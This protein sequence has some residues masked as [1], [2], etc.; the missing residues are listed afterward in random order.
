MALEQALQAARQ[1]ELAVLESLHAA[2]QLGPWLRDPL[3]ALP[4][5]HAARA[6]KLH[7]LR[8][9]VEEAALPAAARARNGATPAHDAAATGHLACLQWLLS[10]GDCRVQDKDSS[11][12][13]ALHLAARFG[14][15]EVVDW[16]LRHGSGDPTAA[17]DMG[18]L[19][20][21]YA[22]A[23]GDFPSLRL[24]I[25]HHPEG[26][27]AQIK[28]GAT[29]LYLACQEGHLEVT[30]YLVQE[31]GAD[32]HLSAH[33][34]MTPLHAA[35]QMGHSSIIVWLV[36]CTDVSLSEQDQDG[37]TAM[38][39]AASRGHAKVLSWLLLHGGEISADLW[40]G[41][42]LHDAAENGELECC[43]ILVV[44]GAELDVRDRDGYTA[45]DLSDYNGHSHCTR[46]LRTVENLSVEH[47]VLSRDPSAELETKQ[48]DSGMSSPNTTMSVQPLNFDLSSPTST[49]SNYDSCSSSQS[50]VK[51][52]CPPRGGSALKAHPGAQSPPVPPLHTGACGLSPAGPPSTRAADI[53]SYMDMLSPE[54]NLAQGE[55]EKTTAPPPPPSFPPPPPP[56]GTQLPPP[57]PGYPAPKPPVGLQAAD[58]YMQTKSKLRHVE[59]QAIRK[60]P[61]SRD[62]HDGLRR[63]DSGRKPRAFS[64]QPSTGDYYRQL[65]RCPRE[66]PAAR[67]GMAHSEEAALLPGNHVHNGCA[68]DPKASRELPPPPPPPPPPLPEGLSSPPP[69]PP[70]PLEGAGPGCGQRRS[71]SSTGSTKSFNMMA[72]TGDNSELLAEIKAGK[73]LKPTPQSKG[74]TTVFSG[75]GQPASQPDSPLP[76]ASPAASRARSPT[77][78]AMGP[79]P[80]LNGSLAPAPPSTP[81]PGVQLDVEALIPT[82]DEQG[83]PI[84]EWKRQV[85]VRKM[86]LKMQEEEEQRRKLTSASSCC[87]PREGWRYSREYNGILGPFGELMTE[88][89]ILRIEQQIENLQV[90]HKAQKLEARL[91]Q[92]ELELEQLL[93]I[94]A[95]LSAP[96]FTVDPRRMH[97][98][99]ASLPA[100]CSKISTLL[101]S[102]ATLLAALGGRPTHLADLL[103]ADTGLPLAP[104]PDAPWRPGP[105]CLGRSH[106]LSWCREAVAREILE[107]GVSVQHLRATYELRSQGSAPPRSPRRKYSLSPGAP[108]REPILEED[109]MAAGTGEPSAAAATNSLPP[110]AYLDPPEVPG[111]QAALPEPE[112]LARRPPL[113]TELRGVQDYIDMRKERIVYLFLEHWRKWTFHGHG[114]QAQTRL[115][116]LLPRVVAAG[117]DPVPEAL[118]AAEVPQPPAGDG[119]DKRLL[120]LLKQRQVVGKLLGHWRSLLRQVPARQPCGPGLAHGLYW[121]EHFL[122]P[123]DGGAPPRYDSLTLDLFMLGYF[124][125]LEMGLSR[126]ERKFRHLLCYEM[127]DRLGSHPWELI[128]EFHRVVL[129]EVEAG[130]RGWSDGFEDLKHQFFGDSP[131]AKLAW[132]EEVKKEQ[133]EAKK[134]QEKEKEEK[135]EEREPAR[136]AVP[137]QTED[138][139][140]GHPEAPGP[141]P[142]PPPPPPPAAPPPTPSDPPSS[143][144]PAEDSL[145]L[146]SGMGEF[147][148]EDICRYIDRSFSFWKEKEAELFDI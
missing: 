142:Q 34:G 104:L 107:C 37:A 82:H 130:R 48:P 141:A 97:G 76:P 61:S 31:C 17:T 124:Q 148:D 67:P 121:P 111:R 12:A 39:F 49:L 125:L 19:P 41:T 64:K 70:L 16:L 87:Y 4:V 94:S 81:A 108:G 78:P 113:P 1:G 56:P 26:A 116:R 89:D 115:R 53:Q 68:A 2:G 91:K 25:R 9:L 136:E 128:R 133:E 54:L 118:E 60:E 52:R 55:M 32:P 5:H 23:K 114:R 20:I 92:L 74:L 33:D 144:A 50:S 90:L 96:R 45:A 10:Q 120:R 75:S 135:E 43:Q 146:L 101:K 102:M 103:A 46:Y 44:N 58:I 73:S 134:E 13:T 84:P 38:H 127:F 131:E 14:H 42:P 88:A 95:A 83:R 69:A 77:P 80:L 66:P 139:P 63:Q 93:P 3:D 129:E 18:A 72:P 110:Q 30:Q 143:E 6:G 62:G 123:L 126:E 65:G 27:N 22:A 15:P 109:Y 85:M 99:A 117:A 105:L 21:H 29:P 47:R 137:A 145:E 132:E 79:Q 122:P 112:Q 71:S 59:N 36:T 98:R 51:G 86:Q 138:W 140:E 40:G 57:P 100:W 24:L 8:F 147:S 28:N 119:P 11:G 106:S 7:C 35:A